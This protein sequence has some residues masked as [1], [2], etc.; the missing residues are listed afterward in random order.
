MLSMRD[1]GLELPRWRAGARIEWTPA[2]YGAV[3]SILTNPC[4]AGAFTF[5]RTRNARRP[6]RAGPAGRSIRQ[7]VPMDQWE[8]LITGHHRGYITWEEYLANQ[9]KLH[10]NCPAPAG[11]GG[12]AVRE[13]RGLLQG[14]L[15]CGRCGRMMRTGF[16][17]ACN[18]ASAYALDKLKHLF[19]VPIVGVIEAGA[20]KAAAATQNQRIAVLGTR[21]TIRSEAYQKEIKKLLP[22]AYVHAIPCPLLVPLV[23]EQWLSHEATRLIVRD[24]LQSLEREGIDTVLL[25]CTHYPLLRDVIQEEAG[26]GIR[27]V[28]SATSCAEKVKDLLNR[29]QLN[30]PRGGQSNHRFYV[31]DDPEK[32]QRL[33]EAFFGKPISAVNLIH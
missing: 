24:Y 2:S 16:I 9:Q 30:T 4:Y 18:T 8:V 29:Y 32:F 20:E 21:G 6:S 31:S 5:G 10:A 27:I 15:R 14:L 26:A 17:V 1:D 3:I 33:G 19:K 7:P 12:G 11:Q 13:G 23:E 22:R 28:D 25:G